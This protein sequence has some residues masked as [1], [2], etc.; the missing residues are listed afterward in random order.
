MRVLLGNH[1]LDDLISSVGGSQSRELEL[2]ERVTP[3]FLK[4]NFH[5]CN[6]QAHDYNPGFGER[7]Q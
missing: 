2:L 7:L 5:E 3:F 4:G 6:D 1:Q